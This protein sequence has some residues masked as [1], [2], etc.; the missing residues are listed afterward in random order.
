VA[1]AEKLV[2]VS[3]G[4]LH[5]G[6]MGAAVAAILCERGMPVLWASEGRSPASAARAEAAGLTRVSS[7][8]ELVGRCSVILSVCPPHAAEDVAR[9]VAGF[10]GLFVEA[11]AVAP[12]TA[13]GIAEI[14]EARGATCVDGGIVGPPPQRAGMARLYLSGSSASAV[15][16]LFE[17]SILEAVVV[18]DRIG[19]AS[20]VKMGYSAWTKGS[21]ALLLAIRAVARREG[22]EAKLLEEWRISQPALHE[23]TLAAGRDAG[24]KGWRWV[25]EMHEIAAMF[26]AAGLPEGFHRAAAEIF[27]RAPRLEDVEDA[28]AALERVLEEL[29]RSSPG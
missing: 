25:A 16:S 28:E 7:L 23:R 26:G 19:A 17:D 22:V 21:A 11:N 9:A 6:E 14:V 5:P 1:S 24:R 13:R 18:S 3:V 2:D 10:G 8:A 29:G 4:L 12:Q 15:A 27:E 20:A